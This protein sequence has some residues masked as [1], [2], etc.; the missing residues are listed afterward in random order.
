MN[1]IDLHVHSKYSIDGEKPVTE[2][3][4]I[5]QKSGLTHIA[6]CD[7]NT[8]A[9]YQDLVD[10][11]V[12]VIPGIELD[13][14]FD[15]TNFHLLGYNIDPLSPIYEQLHQKIQQMEYEG[16]LKRLDYCRNV[17]GLHLDQSA[18]DN[19]CPDHVFIAESIAEIAMS[20]PL[21]QDNQYLKEF[22]PGGTHSANPQVEFYWEYFSEGKPGYTPI[23]FIKMEEAIEL[24]RS[25]G[26]LVVLAHPGQNLKYPEQ[27]TKIVD[28]GI[29]G[30]EAYSNYH[31]ENAK[32]SYRDFANSHN[33]L[34]TCGSDYHGKTKPAIKM[35]E[36]GMSYEE[37]CALVKALDRLIKNT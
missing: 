12:K 14:T 5:A 27:L 4:E 3:L 10:T 24:Y 6:I 34:V 36:T 9:A 2:L 20:D 15:D 26:A 18:L 25:Q 11:P 17:M 16:G 35:G 21:N 7:H 31:S 30:I 13:C 33:L 29:D 32:Q 23:Q 37:Q 22:F 28:L 19:L 1:I 8:A